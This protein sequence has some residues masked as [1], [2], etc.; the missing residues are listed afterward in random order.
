MAKSGLRLSKCTGK[1]AN[2]S[3]TTKTSNKV[4]SIHCS[5]GELPA[6]DGHERIVDG[7]SPPSHQP[8]TTPPHDL[9]IVTVIVL[10]PSSRAPGPSLHR[11]S[12]FLLSIPHFSIPSLYYLRSLSIGHLCFLS[13][14]PPQSSPQIPQPTNRYL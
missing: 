2:S 12:V 3:T 6:Q 14:F 4:E 9:Q 5:M 13:H 8:E 1:P 7:R 11:Q 10:P